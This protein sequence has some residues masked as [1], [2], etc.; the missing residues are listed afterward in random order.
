MIQKLFL[1]LVILVAAAIVG[2]SLIKIPAP[3]TEIHQSIDADK[4]F[5]PTLSIK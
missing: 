2:L 5:K 1:G 3:S 4:I